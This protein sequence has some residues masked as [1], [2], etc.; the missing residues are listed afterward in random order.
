[1]DVSQTFK[2]LFERKLKLK[3]I[4]LTL[5]ED[6][7]LSS[8]RDQ[9]SQW[10]DSRV[11]VAFCWGQSSRA[12]LCLQGSGRRWDRFS[13]LHIL[14]LPPP[15]VS[16]TATGQSKKKAKHA[17]AKKAIEKIIKESDY[18]VENADIILEQLNHDI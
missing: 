9:C 4:D 2:Y 13:C 15:E 16:A 5:T 6:S 14:L 1:M 3:P 12:Y 11:S 10:F 8:A 18:N 17:V 7:D